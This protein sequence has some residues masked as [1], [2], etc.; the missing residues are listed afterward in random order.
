[1]LDMN[2][3][4]RYKDVAKLSGLSEEIVRRV[5]KA[6]R[7]SLSN[8]LKKGCRATI[9]GICTLEPE[10]RHKMDFRTYE[11]KDYIKLKAK[12]SSAMESEFAQIEKFERDPKDSD[13]VQEQDL[14]KLLMKQSNSGIRTTQISALL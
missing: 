2:I 4:A 12:P 7:E 14:L 13:D 3:Q 10:I 6:T 9:P 8:S 5:Y 11:P 1:M